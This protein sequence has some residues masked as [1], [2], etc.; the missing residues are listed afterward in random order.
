MLA[1]SLLNTMPALAA[2]DE[3]LDILE[4]RDPEQG[5]EEVVLAP[6]EDARN[7]LPLPLPLPPQDDDFDSQLTDNEDPDDLES[8]RKMARS[9]PDRWWKNQDFADAEYLCLHSRLNDP[10]SKIVDFSCYDSQQYDKGLL[11]MT[12]VAYQFI[13]SVVQGR[14]YKVGCTADFMTRWYQKAIGGYVHEGYER[15]YILF[16]TNRG[17]CKSDKALETEIPN[18]VERKRYKDHDRSAGRMEI[19]LFDLLRENGEGERGFLN[20][21][22]GSEG[23]TL[24]EWYMVYVSV[25][26]ADTMLDRFVY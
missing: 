13:L 7:P 15:M 24:Y 1:S 14:E 16:L 21:G 18:P 8:A 6:V 23:L 26:E 12:N 11:H 19:R 3:W 22:R 5:E 10:R 2:S 20:K 17:R 25:R 4:D 9:M